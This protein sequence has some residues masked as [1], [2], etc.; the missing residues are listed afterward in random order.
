MMRI[1]HDVDHTI[2]TSCQGYSLRSG[3]LMLWIV[4]LPL[5]VK[6]AACDV[7]HIIATSC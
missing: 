6:D 7:D 1:S 5:A 3:F 2:A 4:S